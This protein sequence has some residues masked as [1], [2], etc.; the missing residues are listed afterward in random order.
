MRSLFFVLIS[1]GFGIG[2]VLLAQNWLKQGQPSDIDDNRQPVMTMAISVPS[3]TIIQEK[4]LVLKS[5]PPGVVPDEV[6]SKPE[7][8]VGMVAKFP[9]IEGDFLSRQKLVPKGEGSVLASLIA[10]NM[11]AVTIRVN[12]VVGVAGFLLPGNRVDVLV[13]LAKRRSADETAQTEVVLS[14]LKVLAV[15][16]RANQDSN[17]PVLVRAVTLEVTLEQ[18]EELMSARSRGNI[19]LALRNPNDDVEVAVASD[20]AEQT[21]QVVPEPVAAPV[22]EPVAPAP[23]TQRRRF[24]VIK[25]TQQ[26]T[27]TVGR[28][29]STVPAPTTMAK[30]DG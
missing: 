19:Q 10:P 30:K 28:E 16:Q 11:R 17:Q 4:H 3:G 22:S 6:L 8:V 9:L 20:E 14:N 24:E 26:Q 7:Q 23:V 15:D 12:D 5:V 2:A 27:I 18:A 1:I 25:G 29:L 13:T 21:A